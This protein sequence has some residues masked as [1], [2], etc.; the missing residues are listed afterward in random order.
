M[1]WH[2]PRAPGASD[3][4]SEVGY[5]SRPPAVAGSGAG[6]VGGALAAGAGHARTLRPDPSP[7]GA[8]GERGRP[9][10]ELLATRPR[11]SRG[12]GDRSALSSAAFTGS[13][14]LQAQLVVLPRLLRL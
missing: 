10:R 12:V 9:P 4:A 13:F 1:P 8:G 7:L 3:R 5:G 11:R 6:L 2:A 14:V